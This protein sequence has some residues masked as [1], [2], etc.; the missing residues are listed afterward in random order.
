[1]SD[2]SDV[3]SKKDAGGRSP[4]NDSHVS[5]SRRAAVGSVVGVFSVGYVGA[6]SYPI[7][8]YLNTPVERAASAAQV[9]EVSPPDAAKVKLGASQTFMFGSRPAVLIHHEDGQWSAFDAVCT[10]L[11]CTV[12]Y[13]SSKDRIYCAC[14]GGVYNAET[15]EPEAGPPPRAL[16]RY[17]VEVKDD[18]VIVSRV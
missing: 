9:T 14:H 12:K 17:K 8:R 1:M 18:E 11:G 5:V 6:V 2:S 10:H 4:V 7:Y 15:G 3:R 13:E 16:T